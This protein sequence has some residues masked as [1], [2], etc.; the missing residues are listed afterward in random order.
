MSQ[1]KLTL[2]LAKTIRILTVPPVMLMA[3][4]V[5]TAILRPDLYRSPADVLLGILCFCIV[6]VLAYPMQRLFPAFREK[7]RDGQRR[8]A[9]IFSLA[10]YLIAVPIGYLAAVKPALQFAFNA[11]CGAVLILV[12]FNKGLHIKASG[13]TCSL[14]GSLIMMIYRIGPVMILPAVLIGAAVAWSS[15]VMKRHTPPQLFFG[16]LSATVAFF[17]VL[18]LASL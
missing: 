4:F 11:F 10:G 1:N 15:L 8:L 12:F 6:P 17:L 5:V 13:H 2:K 14:A 7:G 18:L 3:F 9:F 16:A